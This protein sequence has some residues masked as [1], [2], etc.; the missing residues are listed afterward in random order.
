ME[1]GR[2]EN[3]RT[4]HQGNE[5][6]RAGQ[7]ETGRNVRR[8]WL[9]ANVCPGQEVSMLAGGTGPWAQM[10]SDI[11]VLAG[12]QLLAEISGCVV[13][14]ANGHPDFRHLSLISISDPISPQLSNAL[15]R[16]S[17]SPLS[18]LFSVSLKFYLVF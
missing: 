10:T 14:T 9:R 8:N 17:K 3:S 4:R 1:I 15:A 12:T 16:K 5:G 6:Q 18:N 2:W 13:G 11:Q 7:A